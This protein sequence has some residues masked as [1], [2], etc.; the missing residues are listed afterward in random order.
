MRGKIMVTIKDVATEAGVGVG[1]ASRALSGKGSVSPETKKRIEQAAKK[2]GFV[3][4]QQARNLK[5]QSTGC[6]AVL[7]PT[8]YHP[9]FSKMALHIEDEIYAL[10]D[11]M[12][13]V[14]SQDNLRKEK[15]ILEMIKQRR[16]DGIVFI[17]HYDHGDIDPDLPIVSVDRHLG[18]GIPYVTSNNYEISRA[19]VERLIAGGSRKIGCVCGE[20]AVESE[21][22]HRYEAYLDTMSENGLSAR[23]YKP[24]FRHGEEMDV[25]RK[26]FETYPDVDGIFAGSDMLANAAYHVASERGMNIPQDLQIIGFDGVLREW[27][28][29]PIFTTVEQDIPALAREAVR[30]LMKRIRRE[31]VPSRVEVPARIVEGETTR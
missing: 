26:F 5:K 10:G 3:P 4:N 17:T 12:V 16:V 24:Q 2:L 22:R 6:I 19:A 27:K 14:S 28:G 20:T 21:T 31:E 11:R 18:A 23:L 30:L 7:C 15:I 1:T 25:M 9:F 8:I 29:R 13:V